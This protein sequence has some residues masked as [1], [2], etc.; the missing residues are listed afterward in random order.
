MIAVQTQK[1]IER[2]TE[3]RRTRVRIFQ[4]LMSNRATRLN[5]EFIRALNLI[6]LEFTPGRIFVKKDRAVI[7]AWR[8]LFGELLQRAGEG[9]TEEDWKAWNRRVDDRLVALLKAMSEAL[10]Y[11]FSE[12]ELRR[13][14]YYPQGRVDLEQ[15]Q[16]AVLHGV[17]QALEGK[18]AIPMK[19]TEFPTSPEFLAAQID[20]MQKTTKAYGED[21]ALKVRMQVGESRR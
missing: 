13:G 7:H 3:R 4:T 14:I 12:E 20:M 2:A 15:S 5:E 18:L 10:G 21:G 17:R 1:W 11:T 19:V 8:S 6:D 9:A 16:L